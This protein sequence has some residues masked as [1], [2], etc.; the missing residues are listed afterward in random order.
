MRV[1]PASYQGHLIYI[2]AGLTHVFSFIG[3]PWLLVRSG[4][5]ARLRLKVRDWLNP[6]L[7]AVRFKQLSRYQK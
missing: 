4:E 2:P 7:T 6:R 3:G 5:V 1:L